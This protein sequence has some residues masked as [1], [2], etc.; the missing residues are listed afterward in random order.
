MRLLRILFYSVIILGLAVFFNRNDRED[1][2][3]QSTDYQKHSF[4]QSESFSNTP[5]NSININCNC[6]V[7]LRQADTWSVS[8][9]DHSSHST[10]K[11]HVQDETYYLN[12]THFNSDDEISVV[13]SMPEIQR[14]EMGST[15]TLK[16]SD[17]FQ[18]DE[19]NI[20]MGGATE[21]ELEISASK[22]RVHLAGATEL[23]LS[24]TA[25]QARYSISGA[26][27]L[28]GYDLKSSDVILEIS[29]AGDAEVYASKSLD[30]KV[31][32]AGEVRYK[33]HPQHVSQH[34]SGVGSIEAD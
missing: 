23:E 26:G 34:I 13:I 29:G 15:A 6:H 32:G 28:E 16:S 1:H 25:P 10:L 5:F 9:E 30:A 7:E 20:H 18:T 14:I 31:L 24:G 21:A 12:G 19:L 2:D 4:V 8:F 33:G 11:G 17:E 3:E 27:E 22:L